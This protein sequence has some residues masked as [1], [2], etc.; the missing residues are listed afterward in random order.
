MSA[1]ENQSAIDELLDRAVGAINQGDRATANALAGQVLAVDRANPDAEELLAAPMD[2][3]EIRR[4]T[5]LFADLVDSTALS[6]RVDPEVY[7]TVVGRYRDEVIGIV[8]RY[9]G[10]LCSTKGDGLFAVFGHPRAHE[11]D[12]HRAV[13]AGL[14]IT[15]EIDRL[16][17]RVRR[18]FGF[19]IDVRV[20]IH[21]GLVYLDIAQDDVYGMGANLA[22][23]MCS[24]AKPGTVA[25]SAAIERVVRDQFDLQSCPAKQ[26]KGFDEPIV[27]YRVVAERD[28]ASLA[29][30]PL[31]GRDRELAQ[32][33]DI[34]RKAVAGTLPTPA[35]VLC[36]EGGIGKSRLARAAVDMAERS[37][38]EVLALF[39]SPFYTDVGLRPVRRLLERR[40]GIGRDCDPAE[41]L[42]KLRAEVER[43]AMDPTTM[44][45]LLAPVL[46][47]D[48]PSGYKPVTTNADRLY[49]EITAAVKDYLLACVGAGPGLL[50]VED[51]H[52]FDEDTIE[53]VRTL[54]REN[55]GQLLVI[56]TGRN[57]PALSDETRFELNPLSDAEADTLIRALHPEMKPDARRAV[58]ERCDG[59]PLYIEEV[60]A[61]LKERH[62]D[63]SESTEVPDTLYET[64]VARLGS[65][66]NALVVVEAAA[67]M[68]SRI[69]KRVL[70]SVVNLGE[71]ELTDVLAELTRNR[72]LRA[73]G[74]DSWRFHHELLRE[75]AAELSPPTVRRRVHSRIADALVATAADGRPEWRLVAH[76]YQQAERFDEA[77]SAYQKASANARHR[78]AL[79]EAR[80]HLTRALEN[81]ERMEPNP[82][83]DRREVAVRLE[84]G[85][86]ASTATGQASAEVAAEFE[87][88]LQIIGDE[89]T[90]ELY[91]T[92][93]AL[94]SYCAT[95]GDLR[96]ATH[97][98]EALR[99]FE[100]VAEGYR[101]ANDVVLGML[102]IF[103]GD[104]GTARATLEAAAATL[105]RIGSPSIEGPWFAPYDPVAG[106]YSAIG[107]VRFLQG[108]LAGAESAFAEVEGRCEKLR[109]PQG[110]FTLCFAR[111]LETLTCIEAGRIDRAVELAAEV[112][113]R[114]EQHGFDEYVMVATCNQLTLAARSALVSGKALPADLQEHID[115]MTAVVDA[116]RAA[117]LKTFLACYDAVLAWLLTAAGRTD[118]ARERMR[119]ALEMADETGIHFYDAELLRVRAHTYDDPDAKRTDLFAAIELARRQGSAVFELRAAADN[120]RL[121]GESARGSLQDALSRFPADQSWPELARARA[122]LR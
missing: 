8:N 35:V 29:R 1:S 76:H 112:A 69:D 95:R 64:L 80:G 62:P 87:R 110:P 70:S 93:S 9:E 51:I 85:F 71:R 26:V 15:H 117:E 107:L 34:W 13:Q 28:V 39:G 54:L 4:L 50:L 81:I 46:G 83:R 17:K 66:R 114:G 19:D 78:G 91:A 21:R 61:K 5:M 18:R 2:S 25:V 90:P 14:D 75:V 12:A 57:V 119:L 77:A 3:G 88:C 41:S 106:V 49:G 59:V 52:W 37:G 97:L 67:L 60:V 92:F 24:L 47:I 63:L 42:H 121:F 11:N 98:V 44:V 27:H 58:Q 99:S 40:C 100:G 115:N 72:V 33:Q 36:G 82:A 102:E 68:G 104:F 55:R 74:K 105:D 96:R 79:A 10:H 94:W 23:R 120:Y 56:I 31:V 16:S 84:R 122:L 65:S 113:R 101:A 73:A 118:E 22:A 53:V 6:T 111:G 108:D 86:L 20:G 30:G 109:F 103:Q 89:P 116:W 38:A 43:R 7:R 48:P 45:P 32:L